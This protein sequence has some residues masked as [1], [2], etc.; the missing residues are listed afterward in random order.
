MGLC[1]VLVCCC[2]CFFPLFCT[3]VVVVVVVVVGGCCRCS[4]SSSRCC[5]LCCY[6]SLL[7]SYH[8]GR[9]RASPAIRSRTRMDPRVSAS[10]N[11]S[12]S[13]HHRAPRQRHCTP[14]HGTAPLRYAAASASRP[15]HTR[16]G[17]GGGS[18]SAAAA[19]PTIMHYIFFL[20]TPPFFY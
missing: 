8:P 13:P 16:A 5:R 6:I 3:L 12:S 20:S 14:R 10:K 7:Q 17:D 1:V 19:V 9:E 2:C 18:V 11:L 4:S 15:F